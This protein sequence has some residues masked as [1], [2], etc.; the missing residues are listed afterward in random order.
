MVQTNPDLM[1]KLFII[2][3]FIPL[4]LA[5]CNKDP[6]P[7]PIEIRSYVS[8]HSLLREP[9]PIEWVVDGVTIPDEQAYGARILGA[10]LLENETEEISFTANNF[11]T[12]SLVESLLLTMVSNKYYQIILYGSADEPSLVI[13]EIETT[14]PESGKVKFQ[15]L[16]AAPTIDSVDVYMGGTEVED[17]V[18]TDMSFS[19]LSGYF[20]VFDYEARNSVTVSEH[21][22]VYDPEKEILN[23]DNNDLIVSN[24]N[25]L[26][27]LAYASGDTL[28]S[29]LKLWLYDM[30]TE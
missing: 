2:F 13:E 12:G 11:D 19:E 1:K 22:D 27:V 24:T 18:V 17:R 30:P 15:F 23:Y 25:Y 20:E 21:S 8:V 3:V 14:R 4:L 26:S 9:F 16:H 6:E 28:S 10:V 29:E 5:S 7:Q